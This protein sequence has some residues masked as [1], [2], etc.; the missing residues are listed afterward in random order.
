MILAETEF[1]YPGS[2]AVH[3][4]QR[5]RILQHIGTDRALLS[6]AGHHLRVPLSELADPTDDDVREKALT[7]GLGNAD[8]E[9]ALW[10]ARHLRHSNET[11][12]SQLSHA[13]D[14]ADKD[15]EVSRCY[16][17]GH[18]GG[19]LR[20]LDWTSVRRVISGHSTFVYVRTAMQV[21]A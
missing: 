9:R 8:T 13:M 4:G 16:D 18:L 20:K 19:I 5:G 10:I 14:E 3:N 2:Y 17:R 21:A 15:G 6:I 1:P 7:G 11:T 12:L